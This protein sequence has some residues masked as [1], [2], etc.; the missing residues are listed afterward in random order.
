M[1]KLNI[2]SIYYLYINN[3]GMLEKE[4]SL[5]GIFNEIK[6]NIDYQNF[7]DIVANPSDSKYR[8]KCIQLKRLLKMI[9]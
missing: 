7:F 9:I 1:I 2:L 5:K 4:I 8:K 6:K 3:Y